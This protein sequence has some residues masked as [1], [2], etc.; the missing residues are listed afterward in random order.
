MKISWTPFFSLTTLFL[1]LFMLFVG[2][3]VVTKE[4]RR[5]ARK[6]PSELSYSEPKMVY[7][8]VANHEI[9]L[10]IH[11]QNYEN[12]LSKMIESIATQ[13][14][15]N[16]RII[17]IDNA[18]TDKTLESLTSET[19]HFFTPDQLYQIIHS[20]SKIPL[21]SISQT[22]QS[23]AN[24]EIV[25]LLEGCDWFASDNVLEKINSYY[26]DPK[27]WATIGGYL[28]NP[29]YD[30][31][32][33]GNFSNGLYHPLG[34]KTF[35][36]GLYK[37][38]PLQDLLYHSNYLTFPYDAIP[39]YSLSRL[40]S[41]HIYYVPDALYI[42]NLERLHRKE[43]FDPN[44]ESLLYYFATH[45]LK[46]E[47]LH[48]GFSPKDP[49]QSSI[50]NPLP[51]FIIS[52]NSPKD[53]KH[54]IESYLENPTRF[55]SISVLYKANTEDAKKMY[56]QLQHTYPS[57]FFYSLKEKSY[58]LHEL[59]LKF[60]HPYLNPF[61]LLATDQCKAPSSP[62]FEKEFIEMTSTRCKYYL[63]NLPQ[64]P[65]SGIHF[66]DHSKCIPSINLIQNLNSNYGNNVCLLT[67][68]DH[69]LFVF[70]LW[71]VEKESFISHLL[72]MDFVKNDNFALYP[73]N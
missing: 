37:Q 1:L 34:L 14:Y 43:A 73:S 68:K 58:T 38:I 54:C 8:S 59:L 61:V 60:T 16:F 18:S 44:L 30:G 13:T 10:I 52:E 12:H 9:C 62:N 11:L 15:R 71:I 21:E 53:L 2:S 70:E 19:H 29:T 45:N 47:P 69:F 41:G 17:F 63:L 36:A 3:I 57:V 40:A 39:I 67:T 49:I 26:Q 55:H 50:Y 31:V 4:R 51:V 48:I 27:I 33:A 20:N 46:S 6:K 25:V 23:C 72:K 22:I 28:C 65:T 66:S 7:P 42:A 24:H 32:K 64:Y 5:K 35:Y 56:L